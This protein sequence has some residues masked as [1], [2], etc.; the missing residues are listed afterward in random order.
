M[1]PASVE[2]RF[3]WHVSRAASHNLAETY[4]FGDAIP[5]T[6]IALDPIP[7]YVLYD[8]DAH[9]AT[10]GLTIRQNQSADGTIDPAHIVFKFD[11]TDI[12]GTFMDREGDQFSGFTGSA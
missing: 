4:N 5:A 1:D 3:N 10:V 8:R 6:E 12:N 9:T 7:D 2:N 11:G